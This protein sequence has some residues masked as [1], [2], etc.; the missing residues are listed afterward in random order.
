MKLA[1]RHGW[2]LLWP[3]TTRARGNGP[4]G[5]YTSFT[6]AVTGITAELDVNYDYPGLII[7]RDW[8]YYYAPPQDW[9]VPTGSPLNSP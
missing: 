1:I 6:R 5:L 3:D 4:G 7:S 8:Y 2:I 9:R